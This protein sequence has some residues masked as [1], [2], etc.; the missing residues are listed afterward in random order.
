MKKRSILISIIILIVFGAILLTIKNFDLIV[1]KYEWHKVDKMAEKEHAQ[2]MEKF[3]A[4][5]QLTSS[6]IG[7][8]VTYCNLNSK[9]DEGIGVLQEI[10]KQQDAYMAYFGLSELI[11]EKAKT[12]GPVDIRRSLISKSLSYLKQGFNKV[13]DKAHAYFMRGNAY[14]YLGCLDIAIDDLN[15]SLVE[16]K[17]TKTTMLS[18]GVY[19]DQKRF[20][21]V[22][23]KNITEFKK[24]QN[25]CLL[26][27]IQQK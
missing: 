1:E 5:Q 7:R 21:Q 14:A 9:Y 16:S 26:D 10:L 15:R 23:E 3:K 27:E 24:V 6:E 13:P 12:T 18:D 22:V 2:L 17:K 11:A 20:A 4:G 25:V 19:V 8:I